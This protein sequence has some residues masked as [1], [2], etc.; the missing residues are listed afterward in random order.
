MQKEIA[1][2]VDGEVPITAPGLLFETQ[3]MAYPGVNSLTKTRSF[4]A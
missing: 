2:T 4:G 3:K 1:V